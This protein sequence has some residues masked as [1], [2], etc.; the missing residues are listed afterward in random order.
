LLPHQSELAFRISPA[1]ISFTSDW[2]GKPFFSAVLRNQ[3]KT[4]ASKRIAISFLGSSPIVGLPTRRM[5]D[6]CGSDNSVISEK[7]IFD[8][9]PLSFLTAR[10]PRAD[11]PRGFFIIFSPYCRLLKNTHM[12]RCA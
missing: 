11:E 8:F 6:T 5:D 4:F 9:I 2:Y 1:K 10:A 12:L 3:V 7:L